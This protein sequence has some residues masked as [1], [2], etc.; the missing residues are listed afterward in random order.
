MKQFKNDTFQ[1]SSLFINTHV[2]K[3]KHN[4]NNSAQF[5]TLDWF[6][7]YSF[8]CWTELRLGLSSEPTNLDS[9]RRSTA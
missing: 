1:T 7:V 9:K 5:S 2:A 8:P 6:S 4:N 3:Q